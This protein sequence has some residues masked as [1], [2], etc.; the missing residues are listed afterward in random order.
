MFGNVWSSLSAIVLLAACG[1]PEVKTAGYTTKIKIDI[2]DTVG[3][4][5]TA[6]SPRPSGEEF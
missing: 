6:N 2:N 5:I 4:D 1:A 3:E